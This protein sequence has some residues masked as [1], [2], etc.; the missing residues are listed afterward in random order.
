MPEPILKIDATELENFGKQIGALPS[1]IRTVSA[2][3]VTNIADDTVEFMRRY[4][5]RNTRTRKQVYGESFQSD[6][7][8]K[9]FFSA[10]RSG[11]IKVPYA[12]TGILGRAWR[13]HLKPGET[14][15]TAEITNATPYLPFV[16]GFR[17]EQS[18]MHAGRWSSLEDMQA[19]MERVTPA[20]LAEASSEL[21]RLFLL[22]LG[23]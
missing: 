14:V 15:F 6:R 18:R 1:M 8:R 13:V 9:F 5:S 19:E 22:H 7:Q 2:G 10:V 16:Q 12:R 20:R 3:M 4:P 11:R 17:N 23:R 21:E